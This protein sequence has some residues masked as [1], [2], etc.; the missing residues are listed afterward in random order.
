[1]SNA[2]KRDFRISNNM[3]FH[4]VFSQAGT[5][6]KA[7][8]ELVMNAQ[9]AGAKNFRL[10]IGTD[11]FTASDDGHGFR[12]RNEIEQWFEE[13]GFDHTDDLH[14]EEGRFS[15]FGL[16]RAQIMAFGS[17][18]WLTNTF[19]MSVDIKA[20]GISYELK[21][22]QALVEG[23]TIKG[24]WYEPQSFTDLKDIL[25]EFEEL[26]AFTK[27]AVEVN[28]KVVNRK[29]VKWDFETDSVQV[30]RRESGGLQVY[31]QGVLVKVYPA[32][33]YGSGL[34]V[35]KVPFTLNIARN[36][37]LHSTC[38]VWREV[39]AL[40]R[41]DAV[42]QAKS[43]PRLTE[44]Q[45]HLLLS[46]A[47]AGELSYEDIAKSAL[48]EDVTGR[49]WKLDKLIGVTIT[50]H[51]EGSRALADRIQQSKQA[52]VLSRAMMEAVG[53][54]TPE[55]LV[56]TLERIVNSGPRPAWHTPY[57]FKYAPIAKLIE[58]NNE[59]YTLLSAK[60]LTKTEQV[61]LS[62]MSRG[63]G[64]IHRAVSL[65][66][67][68]KRAPARKLYIGESGQAHAWTDGS[69]YIAINR[70]FLAENIRD[71]FR[72]FTAIANLLV[73]ELC[74]DSNTATGHDHGAEFYEAFHDVICGRFSYC[75]A[76]GIRYM[77]ASFL[78]AAQKAGLKLSRNEARDLDLEVE[79]ERDLLGETAFLEE[80]QAAAS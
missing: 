29:N 9:D 26:I 7:L 76:T 46:Q 51:T 18:D 3:I 59:R 65:T 67:D 36:D 15:R 28:G 63:F 8:G 10:T 4:L 23:C 49:K 22:D 75:Y 6:A 12:S 62:A 39:R 54:D 19:C 71:G 2:E 64:Y 66:T 47:V 74:H 33:Q 24:S 70:Q 56:K 25:R 41:S 38:T 16:G 27:I 21:V 14:Q 77:T 69:T 79:I 55:A 80:V 17:T 53:A 40:L 60:E 32:Y 1:M 13:L 50:V 43:K 42:N 44:D 52:F 11:G 78:G 31:N 61:A 5:I 37:I 73:H 68:R 72:G 45:R 34:V 20:R 48:I 35:S 30:K 58:G 57:E